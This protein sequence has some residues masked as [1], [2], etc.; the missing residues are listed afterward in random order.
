M[1]S[2]AVATL[3]GAIATAILLFAS[4]RWGPNSKRQ[5]TKREELIRQLRE[6][7]DEE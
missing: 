5:V 7:E 3:I 1:I 2:Q 4:S 6:L